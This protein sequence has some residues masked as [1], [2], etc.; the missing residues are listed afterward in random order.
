VGSRIA[1]IRLPFLSVSSSSRAGT[2]DHDLDAMIDAETGNAVSP[3]SSPPNT[4]P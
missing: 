1:P 2:V 3:M 4:R